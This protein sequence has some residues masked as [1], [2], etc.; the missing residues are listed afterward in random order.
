MSKVVEKP[1]AHSQDLVNCNS[2]NLRW[3]LTG[4]CCSMVS[5]PCSTAPLNASR[6]V[7]IYKYNFNL[8]RRKTATSVHRGEETYLPGHLTGEQDLPKDLIHAA[9]EMD[10]VTVHFTL[11][12][13]FSP[14]KFDQLCIVASLARPASWLYPVLLI[15]VQSLRHGIV[16]R[17]SLLPHEATSTIFKSSR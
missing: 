15:F 8:G 10:R 2:R 6:C 16:V 12:L 14:D 3:E 4:K 5:V 7:V 11:P 13:L 1:A 9:F 17:I